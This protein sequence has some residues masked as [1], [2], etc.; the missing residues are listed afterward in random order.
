M[1]TGDSNNNAETTAGGEE[2]SNKFIQFNFHREEK[3]YLLKNDGKNREYYK[4]ENEIIQQNFALKHIIVEG[5]LVLLLWL[6]ER[7]G[8]RSL[9][10]GSVDEDAISFTMPRTRGA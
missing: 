3:R 10:W 2:T 4:R 8:R 1:M 7:L 5:L 9:C 6:W